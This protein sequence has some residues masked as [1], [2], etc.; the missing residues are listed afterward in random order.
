MKP[1][2][3]FEEE[4]MQWCLEAVTDQNRDWMVIVEPTP[5]VIGRGEDCNLKLIDKRI[6]R[7]HCE[8]RRSADHVWIRDLGSTNGTFVNHKRIEQAELLDSGDVI[9]VGQF[10]FCMKPLKSSTTSTLSKTIAM[11][12]SKELSYLD[13]MRPKLQ[14][15]LSEKNVIPFFQPVI[16][17]SDSAAVGFEILGRISNPE[18]PQNPSELLE[19]AQWLGCASELSDLFREMGVEVGSKLPGSPMLF[20][21]TTP[22]ELNKMNLLFASLK[23]IRDAA[24][25]NRI[26]LEINEKAFTDLDEMAK[27]RHGLDTLDMGVAFDDF[28]VGQTRLMEIAKAPPDYL[29]FD[30]SLI[31]QIHLAPVRLHQMVSTFVKAAKDLGI[32]TIAEGI[33][34]AEEAETCKRLG[35]DFAQG[36]FFGRPSPVNEIKFS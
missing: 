11:D 5:F 23:K 19:L 14:A 9:S 22:T 26:V 27:L 32:A 1:D 8:I 13:S 31:H 17:F 20:V 30:V 10:T 16:R 33:E 36:F 25:G 3:K 6:S 7:R 15:L 21:N 29:K 2:M 18:L 24:P 34:C 4:K 35:F 28:G 12:I